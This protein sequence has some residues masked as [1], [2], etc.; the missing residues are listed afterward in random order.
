MIKKMSLKITLKIAFVIFFLS[1]SISSVAQDEGVLRPEQIHVQLDKSFYVA[2]EDVWYKIYF[3]NEQVPSGITHLE[4]R[5]PN[6]DIAL[7]Q[8]IKIQKNYAYGDFRIPI[9]WEEGYY[10]LRVFTNYLMNFAPSFIYTLSLPIFNEFTKSPNP[11]VKVIS[12]KVS[13]EKIDYEQANVQV[14]IQL[15][16]ATYNRREEVEVSLSLLNQVNFSNTVNLSISVVRQGLWSE[17]YEHHSILTQAKYYQ[18]IQNHSI[19]RTTPIPAERRLQISGIVTEPTQGL[20]FVTRVLSLYL[21]ENIAFLRTRSTEQGLFQMEVPDFYGARTAQ[22][23][24]LNPFKIIAPK[25][26]MV[27]FSPPLDSNLIA[28]KLH[29]SAAIEQYLNLSRDRRKF[30]S[31]FDIA[32]LAEF[33][34]IEIRQK[35]LRPDK[36]YAVEE[37]VNLTDV[38]EFIDE[39]YVIARVQTEEGRRTVLMQNTDN[40][41]RYTEPPWYM[42]NGYL[43]QDETSVLNIPIEKVD[44]VAFYASPKNIQQQFDPLLFNTGLIAVYTKEPGLP[45]EI[46]LGSNTVTISGLHASRTFQAPQINSPRIPDFRPL[47]YWNPMVDTNSSGKATLRFKTSDVPGQYLIR[48]EGVDTKGTPVMGEKVLLVK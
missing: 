48:I 9:D 46:K 25:V 27:D 13:S 44:S 3:L 29:R 6:G 8:K 20:P 12:P 39:V 32:A 5:K 2:G 15:N 4:I 11:P 26:E 19:I 10:T 41:F 7:H 47:L 22:V 35:G 36:V 43:T 34:P 31:L 18:N 24:N 23:H 14:D 37:F 30:N 42:V 1:V 28:K 38:G 17:E 21:L 33:A 40:K 16:K 45:E